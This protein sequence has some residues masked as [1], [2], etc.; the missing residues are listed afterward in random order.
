MYSNIFT[1]NKQEVKKCETFFDG[2]MRRFLKIISKTTTE[3]NEIL[4]CVYGVR[5]AERV[6]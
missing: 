5:V 3:R 4:I 2:K 6:K 1:S